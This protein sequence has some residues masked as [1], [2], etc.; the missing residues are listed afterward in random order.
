MNL[1]IYHLRHQK[2]SDIKRYSAYA[3]SMYYRTNV[4]IHVQR[5]KVIAKEIA[6]ILQKE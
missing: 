3:I 6:E 5:M 4:S 2:L 1:A